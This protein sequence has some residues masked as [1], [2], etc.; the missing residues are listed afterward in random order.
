MAIFSFVAAAVAEQTIC[1]AN[2]TSSAAPNVPVFIISTSIFYTIPNIDSTEITAIHINTFLSKSSSVKQV[3][4]ISY[5]CE[6]SRS[7]SDDQM[8]NW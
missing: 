6:V 4:G 5:S 1:T 3:A 7:L 2:P 8:S